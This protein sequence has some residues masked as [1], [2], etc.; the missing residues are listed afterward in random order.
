MI[1]LEDLASWFI[2]ILTI[3]MVI[4][5]QLMFWLPTP[6]PITE[7]EP[8]IRRDADSKRTDSSTRDDEKKKLIPRKF[9]SADFIKNAGAVAC[10][11]VPT[12]GTEESAPT[13]ESSQK[14]SSSKVNG[15]DMEDFD[16]PN[17]QWKCSCEAGFLPPGLLK[18]FGA[19]E[20]VMRLGTGQCYHKNM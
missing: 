16:R 15:M 4:G 8:E 5:V 2:L 7:P 11:L 6:K 3:G 18:S 9:D 20:A 10:T 12:S 1:G 13:K 14:K 17:D 19:A